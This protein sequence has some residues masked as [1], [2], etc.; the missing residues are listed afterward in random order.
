MALQILPASWRRQEGQRF[1]PRRFLLLWFVVV[2][3]FFSASGSKLPSYI[4]PMFPALALL[5]GDALGRLGKRA[6]AAHIGGITLIAATGLL[7]APKVAGQGDPGS[8]PEMM[9]AY[10]VWL[11][12]PPHLAGRGPGRLWLAVKDR[13]LAAPG[14]GHTAGRGRPAGHDRLS[15]ATSAHRVANELKP[16]LA[17]VPPLQHPDVRPDA[18]L[19]SGNTVTLVEYRDE[20][21][22]LRQE[23]GCHP[24]RR[25]PG[26]P[27]EPG[28]RGC[29]HASPGSR[30]SVRSG[31]LDMTVLY[32]PR[33]IVVRNRRN[34]DT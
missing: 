4:L 13:K 3:G 28:F 23:P 14:L 20:L 29:H 19:L 11:R 31:Q 5:L 32:R 6:L 9:A 34:P 16:L 18:A 17:A 15:D 25:R 10:S 1:Q 24:H 26:A 12:P 22:C 21:D 8:P 2:F 33:R 27:L 30:L 7:L